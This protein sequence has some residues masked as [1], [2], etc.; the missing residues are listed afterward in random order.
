M[1]QFSNLKDFGISFFDKKGGRNP[2]RERNLRQAEKD[3][4]QDIKD[5]NHNH[6][7][8]ICALTGKR[9]KHGRIIHPAEIRLSK[10]GGFDTL[11]ML[12]HHSI[13]V[14]DI[15]SDGRTVLGIKRVGY[16]AKISSGCTGSKIFPYVRIYKSI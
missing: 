14:G 16:K 11:R 10:Q 5:G 13:R 7:L 8:R 3:M 9:G 2:V 4:A 1:A 15:S 12:V 6:L